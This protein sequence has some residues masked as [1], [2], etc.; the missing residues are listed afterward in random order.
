MVNGITLGAVYA[1]IAL[2]YTMVY[3]ILELINFAHG[4]I[5]M[6][7]SF[8][9]LLFWWIL[10][11]TGLSKVIP[12]PLAIF[13]MFV[14]SMIATAFLGALLEFI[15]YRPLRSVTNRLIP[16]ISAL[17]AS[18]FLQ[19]FAMLTFGST[20]RVYPAIFPDFGWDI[21]HARISLIQIFIFTTCILMMLGLTLLVNKTKLGRSMRAVAQDY[22]TASL[23]GIRVNRIITI[24]FMIGSSLAAAAGVMYGMYYGVAKFDMGYLAGLKAF[25]A[26][27]LGGI[28]NIPGAMLGGFCL[29]IIESFGAGY[30][31]SEYKDMFAFLM[32]LFILLLRPSG[33][34]GQ[35]VPD[36]V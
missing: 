8:F 27:V 21:F 2:G 30:I 23:M 34:L 26:A 35:Q 11:M 17:G 15:A 28:G 36:K 7:G 3:G 25:T 5:F 10:E 32:L 22:V 29:G 14:F 13:L 20:N 31:S 19:N 33:L 1:L 16:L 4:E 9:G 24:T 12:I 6:M 18:I